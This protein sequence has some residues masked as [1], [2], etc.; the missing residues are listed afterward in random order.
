MFQKLFKMEDDLLIILLPI[1]DISHHLRR[2]S[3][4][5][6]LTIDLEVKQNADKTNQRGF[7]IELVSF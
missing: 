5:K 1:H 2:K 7:F 3:S 4:F 6:R